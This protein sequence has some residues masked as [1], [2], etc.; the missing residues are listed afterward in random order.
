[1]QNKI[2]LKNIS[3]LTIFKLNYYI[4]VKCKNVPFIRLFDLNLKQ[5]VKMTGNQMFVILVS[6][7]ALWLVSSLYDNYVRFKDIKSRTEIQ[8]ELNRLVDKR[9]STL[10]DIEEASAKA[11]QVMSERIMELQFTVEK[12][13]EIIKEKLETKKD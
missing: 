12:Q 6:L 9:L 3:N 1:L 2:I 8:Q 5:G 7:I 10:V 11:M 4:I 13:N